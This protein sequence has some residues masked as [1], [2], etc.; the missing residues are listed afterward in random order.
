MRSFDTLER[1]LT[2][3]EA[4]LQAR[5]DAAQAKTLNIP[6]L[7]ISRSPE[8]A[9]N[10]KRRLADCPEHLRPRHT[11]HIHHYPSLGSSC[12]LIRSVPDI[13]GDTFQ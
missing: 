3:L 5:E 1:R 9:A 11:L 6:F 2:N 8:E 12:G 13:V 4:K 10:F 7:Q